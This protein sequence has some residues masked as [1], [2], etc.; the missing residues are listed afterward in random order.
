MR[1]LFGGSVFTSVFVGPKAQFWGHFG[2]ILK[3]Q[4]SILGSF[5][6]H[7][8]APRPHFVVIW[9]TGW[10]PKAQIWAHVVPM[11]APFVSARFIKYVTQRSDPHAKNIKNILSSRPSHKLPDHRWAAVLSIAKRFTL[12]EIR[13]YRKPAIT[14]QHTPNTP[15][16]GVRRT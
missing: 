6:P 7:F 14:S 2:F 5:G 8:E 16:S 3:P 12:T 4:G 11:F 1:G 15:E 13:K 10:L 9:V